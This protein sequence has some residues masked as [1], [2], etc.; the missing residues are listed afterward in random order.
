M[1]FQNELQQSIDLE[2][3]KLRSLNE[4]N[5]TLSTIH[6]DLDLNRDNILNAVQ[7]SNNHKKL[8]LIFQKYQNLAINVDEVF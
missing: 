8:D 1:K 3:E 7:N 6:F 5:S 2:N 4:M